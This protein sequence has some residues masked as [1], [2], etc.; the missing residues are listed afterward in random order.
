MNDFNRNCACDTAVPC[1]YNDTIHGGFSSQSGNRIRPTT[2]KPPPR[3][4]PPS[5]LDV[6]NESQQRKRR[7][8]RQY[9]PYTRGYLDLSASRRRTTTTPTTTTTEY[10]TDEYGNG[11]WNTGRQIGSG[12]YGGGGSSSQWGNSNAGRPGNGESGGGGNYGSGGYPSPGGEYGNGGDY[13]DRGWNPTSTRPSLT[14]TSR[15]PSFGSQI[16][17]RC[18]GRPPKRE[19]K[20]LSTDAFVG[21]RE[22]ECPKRRFKLVLSNSTIILSEAMRNKRFRDKKLEN[23]ESCKVR[24]NRSDV[25][26]Y[27]TIVTQVRVNFS[28]L[29]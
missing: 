29:L 28:Y 6:E 14:S 24:W 15:S 27:E 5:N 12:S 19:N 23:I 26:Y 16:S 17:G 10:S 25:P 3:R 20:R 8:K 22:P 21:W 7:R 9:G 2:R 11:D 1:P 13:G 4:P 18:S